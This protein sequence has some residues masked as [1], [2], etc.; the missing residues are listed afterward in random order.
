[1]SISYR[2]NYHWRNHGKNLSSTVARYYEPTS[3]AEVQQ[4]VREAR[5]EGRKVRVVGD[6]HSWSP[7]G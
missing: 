5:Q 7:P 4:I 3:T 2:A 6:S 1:M